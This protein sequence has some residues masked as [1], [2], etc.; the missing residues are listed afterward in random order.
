MDFQFSDLSFW[1]HQWLLND[2]DFI[3]AGAGIVGLSAAFHLK[4]SNPTTKIII[5]DKGVL[6]FSA[7]SKNAGFAC[8]GSPSELI[9]DL[10]NIPDKDVWKTVKMRW[11]G[12]K[13]LKNWLGE[14]EIDLQNLGSWD[15]MENK[16]ESEDIRENL[17]SLNQSLFEIT[18]EK[19]VFSE[20]K[21]AIKRFGFENLN[22][23]FKN[24]LEGQLDT[25]KLIQTA[26]RKVQELGITILRGVEMKAYSSS[27]NGV[28]LETNYGELK[29]NNL[30][31]CTNG[32]TS[33]NSTRFDLKP[34]RAQVLITNKIPELKTIGTFHIDRGYY[35]LRNV[36]DRLLIG[37]GRNLNF[38]KEETLEI[39]ITEEIQA[40]IEDKLKRIILP[41]T[42]FKIEHR[43]AGI[44]GVGNKKEPIIEQIDSRVSVGIRMGGMGVAIGTLVG[45]KLA[46]M[47]S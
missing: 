14:P 26:I 29:T 41:N 25:S 24:K 22:A 2:I 28:F 12:L 19:N 9:D 1:E 37:G 38:Q 8:F 46:E 4:K 17:A 47:N 11:E 18:G 16:S 21:E 3:V 7:S 31:I 13:A 30:V 10:S 20:D 36:C 34:A 6:P 45:Q 39:S 42:Q 5:I 44:M 32:F 23:A 15:L 33:K 35:Y 40:G 43:W 27:E